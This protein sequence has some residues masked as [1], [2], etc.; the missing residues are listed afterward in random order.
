MSFLFEQQINGNLSFLNV[1][2][3]QQ[4]GKFV[5]TGYRKLTFSGVYTHFDSFLPMVYKVGMIY[6]LAY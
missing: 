1:E 4:R 6:A 5:T 2:V 3:S